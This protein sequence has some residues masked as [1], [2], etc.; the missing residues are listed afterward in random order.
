[1]RRPDIAAM[2]QVHIGIAEFAGT[3]PLFAARLR[4]ICSLEAAMSVLSPL[5][6]SLLDLAERKLG[7][8]F[9]DG[10]PVRAATFLRKIGVG[11]GVAVCPCATFPV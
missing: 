7:L 9:A 3:L 8:F 2:Q 1:M 6:T 10:P 5:R 4:P 11:R